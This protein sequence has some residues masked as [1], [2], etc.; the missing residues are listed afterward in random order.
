MGKN[1]VPKRR[2]QSE[3]KD[4]IGLLIKLLQGVAESSSVF[5]MFN[6]LRY[7]PFVINLQADCSVIKLS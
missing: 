6:F 4:G 5:F 3:K 1:Y 7:E 2:F